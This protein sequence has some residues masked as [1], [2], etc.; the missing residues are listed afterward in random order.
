MTERFG[1]HRHRKRLLVPLFGVQ[2]IEQVRIIG[3]VGDDEHMV[4]VFGACP[5]HRGTTDVDLFDHLFGTGPARTN[6][7]LERIEV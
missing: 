6:R 1:G 2:D 3:R 5:D 4:E 7:L